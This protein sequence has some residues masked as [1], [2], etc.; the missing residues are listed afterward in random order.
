MS[1]MAG[2]FRGRL[3]RITLRFA[4]RVFSF[5]TSARAQAIVEGPDGANLT[6]GAVSVMR[7]AYASPYDRAVLLLER[8]L[9]LPCVAQIVHAIL[10]DENARHAGDIMDPT[11]PLRT[12]FGRGSTLN[13]L[14]NELESP[15][16]ATIDLCERRDG[17]SLVHH[18]IELFWRGCVGAGVA[19]EETVA[20]LAPAALC[21]VENDDCFEL[22]AATV[23]AIVDV[24]QR[25]AGC[26]QM[27]PRFLKLRDLYPTAHA[28]AG[29]PR[30]AVLA[31]E[32]SRTE[33]AY[34]Q[35]LER[36]V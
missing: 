25:R 4:A 13:M 21:D 3:T 30:H 18:Q 5:C 2:V 17:V 1:H 35:D 8:L 10:I 23:S 12:L 28:L 27:D 7:Q 15:F 14:V 33:V 6:S 20:R 16:V 19:A 32:L 29:E 11:R 36:L 9:C 24:L 34:V 26:M 22:M 31:S